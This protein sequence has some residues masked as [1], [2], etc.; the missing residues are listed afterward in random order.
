VDVA[1]DHY[2]GR[3]LI[4]KKR[5]ECNRRRHRRCAIE[6]IRGSSDFIGGGLFAPTIKRNQR[7]RPPDIVA[8]DTIADEFVAD[9]ADMAAWALSARRGHFNSEDEQPKPDAGGGS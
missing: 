8:D 1:A 3:E 6:I 7:S 5:Q 9:V 4:S 2:S